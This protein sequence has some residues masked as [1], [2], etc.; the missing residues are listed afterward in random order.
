M[1]Y[2]LVI[3]SSGRHHLLRK[4]LDSFFATCDEK[5][6]ETII[7]EDGPTPAP[8]WLPANARWISNGVPR[9][10]IFSVDKAYDLVKTPY[11]FHAEDD[12]VF[13]GPGYLRESYDILE[14]YPDIF[15]VWLRGIPTEHER[16]FSRTIYNVQPHQTY[17]LHIAQYHWGGWEGGFSF[18]PGLRRLRDYRRIGTYGRYVGYD[19]KGCGERALGVLYHSL[20]F[21]SAIL[22]RDYVFHIGDEEH[23]D[24]KSNPQPP[25]ILVAVP[26]AEN[27]DYSEFR[28]I[29]LRTWSRQWKHGVSGL[30]VDGPNP[31][32]KAVEETWF[33][34]C[35]AFPNVQAEFFTLP[36]LDDHVHLPHKMR[37][38]CRWMVEQ[39]FNLMF[40]PDDDTYVDVSRMV[41]QGIELTCDY[42]GVDQGGFA[43]GGP[44]IWMSRKAC[45]IVAQATPPDYHTEWRDDAWM[46]KVLK[47]A[48]IKLTDLPM[49]VME[50][51]VCLGPIITRH[52]VS[53]DQMRM[54]YHETETTC[55]I[56]GQK[57]LSPVSL[58]KHR[59]FHSTGKWP[60]QWHQPYT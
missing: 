24:R 36:G 16:R 19:P 59:V 43:I 55:H 8:D 46:G 54:Y 42:G 1:L 50:E 35:A 51:N 60:S 58:D 28:N 48:G 5:P 4:T 47:D 37:A 6:Y 17:P 2:T 14:K 41:R 38:I 9:G 49:T 45:E 40:R 18:N 30:Q 44:G 57:G 31:R 3:T 56:C 21:S 10:Q 26:T 13:R 22:P 32:R 20:G 34:D 29:Q 12:W 7:I 23:V 27:L 11:I 52:P 53:P 39:N 15:Q 25:N 33:K